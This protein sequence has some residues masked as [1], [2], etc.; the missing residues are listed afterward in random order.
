[1]TYPINTEKLIQTF[2]ASEQT[3]TPEQKQLIT[4]A[5][6]FAV[7]LANNAYEQGFK[8]GVNNR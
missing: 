3:L 4:T 5:L 7:N 8:E 2:N 6:A 1:M